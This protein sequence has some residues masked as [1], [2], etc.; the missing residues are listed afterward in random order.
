MISGDAKLLRPWKLP[1]EPAVGLLTE[2]LAADVVAVC[3][4]LGLGCF[5]P[6]FFKH[7]T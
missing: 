7:I 1:E 3:E 4:A 6:F 2:L 5:I